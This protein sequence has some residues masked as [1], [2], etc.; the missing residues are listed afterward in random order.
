MTKFDGKR[1]YLDPEPVVNRQAAFEVVMI[2]H[3]PGLADL[4]VLFSHQTMTKEMADMGYTEELDALKKRM[5]DK[6]ISVDPLYNLPIPLYSLAE[7][8]QLFSR[9]RPASEDAQTAPKSTVTLYRSRLAGSHLW[10]PFAVEDFFRFNGS[11]ALKK[12]WLI[13]VD[14]SLAQ[15]AFLPDGR[16]IE[17]KIPERN[18]FARA[19]SLPRAALLTMPDLERLQIPAYIEKVPNDA[20]KKPVPQFLPCGSGLEIG[21]KNNSKNPVEY[22][23][24]MDFGGLLQQML[25]A[26]SRYKPDLRLLMSLP[27]DSELLGELPHESRDALDDLEKL[28]ESHF[29]DLLHRVQIIYPYVRD[30]RYRL[31]TAS[32][33]LAGKM[34]EVVASKGA[35]H[36]IAGTPLAGNYEPFPRLSQQQI[37]ILRD[38]RNIGV[39]RSRLQK[40]E[41]DD[42]RLCGGVFGD[43]IEHARSGEISRFLGWLQRELEQLGHQLLFTTDPADPQPMIVLNDFFNRLHQLGAL[44]GKNSQQAFRIT[45]ILSENVPSTLIFNIEIAPVFPIDTIQL[46]LQQDRLEIS[47]G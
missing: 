4:D 23:Q 21:P 7:F 42:E 30:H 38:R 2:G 29:A 9:Q 25:V 40:T 39:L 36:S 46:R 37:E 34:A 17:D 22:P 8:Q 20:V 31:M 44:R 5:N 35:W 28:K 33:L 45:R 12:L 41:L 6:I 32:G 13:N 3:C 24:P 10:L 19:L 1:I 15:Q 43:D 26:I 27:L 16:G 18:A 14:Q 47:R 11:R